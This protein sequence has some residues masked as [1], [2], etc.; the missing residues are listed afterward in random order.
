MDG[1]FY[2][3]VQM[4]DGN[5]GF[6]VE[7]LKHQPVPS[8]M[9][10][11]F[12]HLANLLGLAA[13]LSLVFVMVQFRPVSS[14][15]FV[16]TVAHAAAHTFEQIKEEDSIN[17][18]RWTKHPDTFLNL[19][20]GE[21]STVML[22]EEA[23]TQCIKLGAECFGVTCG[24]DGSQGPKQPKL[25]NPEANCTV[26]QGICAVRMVYPCPPGATRGLQPSPTHEVSFV[27]EEHMQALSEATGSRTKREGKRSGLFK[28]EA[29]RPIP[30]FP[31]HL[32]RAGTR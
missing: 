19:Y 30:S 12:R 5:T 21:N 7:E 16:A 25:Q 18:A 8:L 32:E 23:K 3:E 20:A 15:K 27:K 10:P 26:R 6:A 14:E 31:E 4:E 17:G 11:S 9:T 29:Q 24:Y 22:L 13:V 1:G 28:D 2:K